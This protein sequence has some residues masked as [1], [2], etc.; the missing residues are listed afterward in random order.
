MAALSVSL[1]FSEVKADNFRQSLRRCKPFRSF[2]QV[3]LGLLFS[4][5]FPEKNTV[6]R[7]YLTGCFTIYFYGVWY[8][9]NEMT[10]FLLKLSCTVFLRES[11]GSSHFVS[12]NSKLKSTQQNLFGT[13]LVPSFFLN[14]QSPYRI[15]L[16]NLFCTSLD[17]ELLVNMRKSCKERNFSITE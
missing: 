6:H 4:S 3:F 15:S 12:S 10:N 11:A 14:D 7:A 1:S 5:L 9:I 17:T 2:L 13:K 8:E 16:W